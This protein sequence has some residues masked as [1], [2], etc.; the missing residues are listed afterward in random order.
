MT[1]APILDE[2]VRTWVLV[3]LAKVGHAGREPALVVWLAR[4]L[5]DAPGRLVS[6]S[7]AVL[8]P[9]PFIAESRAMRQLLEAIRVVAPT[10]A[11]VLILGESGTGKELVA[12][13]LHAESPRRHRPL[14]A[15]NCAA[16]P[17]GLLESELFGHERG[18]FT[19]ATGR[20]PGHFELAHAGTL[21]LDEVADLSPPTQ[22]KLLRALQEGEIRRLGGTA[23]ISVDA[24]IVAA[25]NQDLATL[26]AERRFRQDLYYRLK[27]VTLTVPPLRDRPED[28]LP[29]AR[30]FLRR[31][32]ADA[33]RERL[34]LAREAMPFLLRYPWPGN[35]REL[36][37]ALQRAAI[38]ARGPAIT[39]ED[40][41]L[42]AHDEEPSARTPTR[43]ADLERD[44][45]LAALQAA[46]GNQAE[47]SR[48][49]GID[50][51]TLWRKL[52][53]WAGRP[54]SASA[55]GERPR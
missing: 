14:V 36:E 18:A 48:R 38:L 7:L 9:A 21:F 44:N 45:V 46:G 35:V 20:K 25:A 34:R 39:V 41:G 26:A 13:T 8:V 50:R 16:I 32:A 2:V 40:L 33:P 53:R 49:L 47:A 27:V 15:V 3:L 43:L 17:E 1:D 23:L 24:R 6:L 30:H 10:D 42:G 52:R 31:Y 29:L 11:T 51:S 28:I 55:P 4:V 22:A 37:H 5:H 12:R 54:P 19:G